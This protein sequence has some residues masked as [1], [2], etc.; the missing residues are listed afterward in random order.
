MDFKHYLLSVQLIIW[1]FDIYK[2]YIFLVFWPT[3]MCAYDFKINIA[4]LW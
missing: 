4:L 1:Y 3:K 2:S